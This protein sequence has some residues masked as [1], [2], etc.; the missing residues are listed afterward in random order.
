MATQALCFPDLGPRHSTPSASLTVALCL[1]GQ[2]VWQLLVSD[3][4]AGV[5]CCLFEHANETNLHMY[6]IER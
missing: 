3:A 2:R 6:T 5:S 4:P 1:S